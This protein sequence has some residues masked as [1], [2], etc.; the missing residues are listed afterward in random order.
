[1]RYSEV[2]LWSQ[3]PIASSAAAVLSVTIGTVL[4]VRAGIVLRVEFVQ[5]QRPT[6]LLLKRIAANAHRLRSKGREHG[7]D[8]LHG[9]VL[10][11][12]FIGENLEVRGGDCDFSIIDHWLMPARMCLPFK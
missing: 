11:R 7:R 5:W 1:M 3:R 6:A 8:L 10:H 9:K 2:T 4:L 12:F